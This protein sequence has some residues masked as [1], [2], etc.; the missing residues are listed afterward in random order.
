MNNEDC[1]SIVPR[2]SAAADDMFGGPEAERFRKEH[3]LGATGLF[4]RGKIRPDDEGELKLGVAGDPE[5]HIVI[6][7]FGKNVNW[8]AMTPDDAE[9]LAESLRKNAQKARG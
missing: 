6:I 3:G 9:A 1:E 4:P 7:D 2:P 8:M 5:N